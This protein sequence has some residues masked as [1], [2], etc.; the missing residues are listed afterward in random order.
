MSL[1]KT[2]GVRANTGAQDNT[3]PW[4]PKTGTRCPRRRCGTSSLW[5]SSTDL[6]GG[7]GILAQHGDRPLYPTTP[8]AKTSQRGS[9]FV[10]HGSA[11][12]SHSHRG[13]QVTTNKEPNC[14]T[15]HIPTL[16]LV[17]LNSDKYTSEP[18]MVGLSIPTAIA[19]MPRRKAGHTKSWDRTRC[20]TI[21][22][23]GPS[24]HLAQLP[25]FRA[26]TMP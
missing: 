12:R 26:D 21:V 18:L 16:L 3:D 25:V 22:R 2:I 11:H 1:T 15:P 20:G 4:R 7:L 23:A 13:A 14:L 6:K 19:N 10:S 9:Y 5:S 17:T 8:K 24:V